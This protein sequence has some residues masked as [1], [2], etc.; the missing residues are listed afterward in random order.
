MENSGLCDQPEVIA[1]YACEVGE[2]P[3]WHPDNGTILW[4]DIPK[5]RLFQYQPAKKTT[6]IIYT[7]RP[8][9]G[10]TI[11]Q[12]GSLLLF[13]DRGT[14]T[15]WRGEGEVVIIP[16]IPIERELRFNDVIADPI[17]RV[18]CGTYTHG[19]RGRLYRLDTDGTLTKVLDDI[20][21]SNGMAFTLD[22]TG[23]FYIDSF[24]QN[25][26]LFDYD[27]RTGELSNQRVFY[28]VPKE[29]GSP[30]GCTLDEHGYLWYALWGG[31]AVVRLNPQGEVVETIAMPAQKITSL[32]FGGVDLKTI[33][34]T[35]E[36]GNARSERD[37]L[38]GATFSAN[39]S[40]AGKPEFRSRIAMN[41]AAP[42]PR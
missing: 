8:V 28:S 16:E 3:L 12:D 5:G 34:V 10:F 13:K 15:H 40:V 38:A 33:F 14:V 37:L 42:A 19:H 26:Y 20:G 1:D 39:C 4:T 2:N 9:G 35:S 11:Q 23:M 32:S 21:C 18:F 30:D 24:A 25:I 31:S 22:R 36:G 29:Q 41:C 27:E 6:E 7:G 17:G